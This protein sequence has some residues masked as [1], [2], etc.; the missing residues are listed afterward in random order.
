MKKVGIVGYRGMVGSVLMQRMQE[1]GDFDKISASFFSTSQASQTATIN[2]TEYLLEDA[3]D[4][5][6]LAELDIIMTCQGS[7]YSEQVLPEL[8]KNGWQGYWIDAASKYRM[9]DDSVIVLDPVNMKNIKTALDNGVKNF[10]GGNCTVSLLIMA[11]NGLLQKQM[12]KSISV[13]SYQAVSG[14]GSRALTELLEQSRVISQDIKEPLSFSKKS[15][16]EILA[17]NSLDNSAL[18]APIGY[19]LIPFIDSL[20]DNGQTKEE[21]KAYTELNKILDTAEKINIDGICVRVP[22]LRA[23]SQALTIELDDEYDLEYIQNV[24]GSANEYVK[25]VANNAKDTAEKLTPLAV[26]GKLDIA[27]GRIKK[28]N[29]SNKHIQLFTVGDQLLWGAAEPIRRMLNICLD[30]SS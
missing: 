17:N 7:E 9:S 29:I 27:V 23:H 11:I 22:V 8:R 2:N 3:Y 18:A 24:I 15:V 28:T 4:Y 26:S 25:I 21:N 10:I 12:V 19:N 6:K 30:M 13:M 5:K 20:L 1:F 16:G 14:S